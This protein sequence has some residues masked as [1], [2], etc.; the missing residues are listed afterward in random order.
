MDL[1]VE[2]QCVERL[3]AGET[4]QF[5]NLFDANFGEVF[6]YLKRRINDDAEVE[7]ILRFTFLEAL[8]LYKESPKDS[9]YL[10]WLLSLAK[11][12]VYSYLEGNRDFRFDFSSIL[13][14]VANDSQ[15]KDISKVLSM[16]SK[17]SSEESEIIKLKFF[18]QVADSDIMIILGIDPESVGAR[19]YRV[20]KRAHFLIFGEGNENQGVYF[21]ELSGMLASFME[22]EKIAVP[23]ALRL[24]FKAQ[25]SAKIDNSELILDREL[26]KE[27]KANE[28]NRQ[29]RQNLIKNNMN[30]GSNDPAKVFV[31]AANSMNEQEKQKVYDEYQVKK[32]FEEDEAF[33]KEMKK[34]EFWEMIDSIKGVLIFV[35]VMIFILVLSGIFLYKYW[36]FGGCDFVVAYSEDLTEEE[37][38]D[39]KNKV[40]NPICKYYGDVSEMT[41]TRL[42]DD[43]VDVY[44]VRK[45]LDLK[46]MFDTRGTDDWYV[47]KFEKLIAEK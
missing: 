8:S 38:S 35:P 3:I 12:R 44:A 4:R 31:S 36:P 21:G 40:A 41:I 29:N 39:L 24:G 6:K 9:S 11:K 25:L 27:M 22:N 47:K 23:E 26:I 20:L 18:E 13:K 42:S 17:L 34:D 45:E 19:I 7:R 16:F 10:V 33:R 14:K 37:I 1:Y 2:K 32:Q 5:L 30:K 43:K 28:E 15:E 46:Y